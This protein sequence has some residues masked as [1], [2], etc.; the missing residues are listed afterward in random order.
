LT[1]KKIL[2]N[3]SEVEKIPEDKRNYEVDYTKATNAGFKTKVDLDSGLNE[4]V[5][6]CQHISIQNK[7]S[8]I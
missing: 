6:V 3:I 7:Y 8:N 1:L 2:T 5:K 4:L